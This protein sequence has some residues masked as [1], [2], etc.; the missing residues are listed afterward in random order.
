[1]LLWIIN[2]VY[3]RTKTFYSYN[4]FISIIFAKHIFSFH[5]FLDTGQS[6]HICVA[7]DFLNLNYVWALQEKTRGPEA[8]SSPEQ[9][10][11]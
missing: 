11:P 8:T 2:I 9:Q 1:M 4:S 6:R 10:L 7:L 3:Y 5:H